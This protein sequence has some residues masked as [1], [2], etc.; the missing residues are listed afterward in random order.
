MAGNGDSRKVTFL[1]YQGQL[2]GRSSYL[3]SD[4][5]ELFTTLQSQKSFH[6]TFSLIDLFDLAFHEPGVL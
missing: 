4:T 3:H 5:D 1:S 6:T 2:S